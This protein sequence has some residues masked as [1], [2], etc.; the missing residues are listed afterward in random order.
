M[1]YCFEEKGDNG[2]VQ[3]EASSNLHRG[4]HNFGDP[5]GNTHGVATETNFTADSTANVYFNCQHC[6]KRFRNKES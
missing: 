3:K 1:I 4:S 6:W 2:N 5:P